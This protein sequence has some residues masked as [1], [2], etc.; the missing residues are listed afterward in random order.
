[1]SGYVEL[2]LHYKTESSHLLGVFLSVIYLWVD[3][4]GPMHDGGLW[5]TGCVVPLDWN[6]WSNSQPGHFTLRKETPVLV[7]QEAG[8]PL[9]PV[10]VLLRC[11]KSLAHAGNESRF[12][13]PTMLSRLGWYFM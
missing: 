1:M 12:L 2:F 11:E 3:K 10:W 9:D 8:W 5:G 13:K 7:V 6:G 4:V